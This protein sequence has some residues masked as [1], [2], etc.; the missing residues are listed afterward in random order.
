MLRELTVVEKIVSTRFQRIDCIRTS[1]HSECEVYFH[2]GPN[3]RSY[4]QL[5]LLRSL[6]ALEPA[7][8]SIKAYNQ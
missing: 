5:Q 3:R 1:P 2:N 7:R 4:C 6:L 8:L